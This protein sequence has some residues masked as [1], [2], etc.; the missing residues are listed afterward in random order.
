M[1]NLI[2]NKQTRLP[3]EDAITRTVLFFS[4]AV[5]PAPVS[6]TSVFVQ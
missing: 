1:G 4:T 3:G 5:R 2:L 6:G